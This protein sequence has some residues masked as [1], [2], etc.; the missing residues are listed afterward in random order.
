MIE[1][2]KTDV[3]TNTADLEFATS[4][5]QQARAFL[6]ERFL[7]VVTGIVGKRA[8]FHLYENTHV[9]G[10]FRGC[11]VECSEIFVRNL[12]TPIGKIPD[13]VLRSNDIIYLDIGDISTEQ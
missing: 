6:R 13:A 4:E 8:E 3:I 2:G 7:R 11:D 1:Q 10:E 9:L 5:K 12:E